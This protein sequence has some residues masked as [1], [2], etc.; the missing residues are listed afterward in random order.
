MACAYDNFHYLSHKII[1]LLPTLKPQTTSQHLAA[2]TKQCRKLDT[3]KQYTHRQEKALDDRM[4]GNS[5]T[6]RKLD[7]DLGGHS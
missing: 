1:D 7:V 3:D 5:R 2:R 4:L 6:R